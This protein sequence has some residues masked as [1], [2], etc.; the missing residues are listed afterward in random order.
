ME[1]AVPTPILDEIKKLTGDPGA[2][3]L[4]QY[5]DQLKERLDICC[6]PIPAPLKAIDP[7][8]EEK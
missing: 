4:A 6:P 5:M 2:R 8:K 1:A 3:R 7:K